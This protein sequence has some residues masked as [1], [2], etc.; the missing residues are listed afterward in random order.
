MFYT[1]RP[2]WNVETTHPVEEPQE[3]PFCA[4]CLNAIEPGIAWAIDW[5]SVAYGNQINDPDGTVHL[6]VV[7]QIVEEP[8]P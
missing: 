6:I 3:G 8:E 5:G 1:T 4:T 7:R 2:G